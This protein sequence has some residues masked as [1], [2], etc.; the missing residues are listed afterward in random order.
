MAKVA[1]VVVAVGAPAQQEMGGDKDDIFQDSKQI[2][3][4]QEF[5]ML[6]CCG[7]EAK[8][9]YRV[10]VP[11][12]E[13]E[14]P[15]IFLYVSEDSAC[16]ERICCHVNRSLTLNVHQGSSKDGT[17]VQ[18]M[19]KPFHC[20]GCCCLRPKFEVFAGAKGVNQIGNIEDP[21]RCC[22]MDQQVKDS[23]GELVYT[24]KGSICQLGLCCPCCGAVDFQIKKP[25]DSDVGKISRRPLTCTEMCQKTNRF[26]IDFPSDATPTNK[27]LVFAA[28]MLADLEYFEQNKNNDK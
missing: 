19:H 3:V 16:C 4:K 10:S 1:P 25:D 5:A 13:N 9:R 12:G 22:S 17:I 26:T 15:N 2:M 6:E 14:G 24:T 11:N 21:C 7:C 20:Q 27:R 23:K 8:N 18:S 28:A